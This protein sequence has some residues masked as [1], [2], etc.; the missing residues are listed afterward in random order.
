MAREEKVYRLLFV[1]NYNQMPHIDLLVRAH[2]KPEA[3][4]KGR[5]EVV[6]MAYEEIKYITEGAVSLSSDVLKLSP[7]YFNH[8]V[9]G[10]WTLVECEVQL[11]VSKHTS[12]R[13]ADDVAKAADKR[14][15]ANGKKRRWSK[16]QK[17]ARK[18]RMA[19]QQKA[20]L[21]IVAA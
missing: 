1:D 18:A 8:L 17:A 15:K 12:K 20:N 14:R 19:E 6:R 9:N 13:S 11:S 10:C 5:A 21:S 7:R 2:N 4:E 16:A 3:E